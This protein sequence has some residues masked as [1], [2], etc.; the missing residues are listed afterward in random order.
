MVAFFFFNYL[1]Q[2][3]PG[4]EQKPLD[5]GRTVGVGGRSTA[6][7]RALK[8]ALQLT[9]IAQASLMF[10]PDR[11][12]R[13]CSVVVALVWVR[14][15][16]SVRLHTSPDVTQISRLDTPFLFEDS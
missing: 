15:M 9:A 12:V 16:R 1:V 13:R 11:K 8:E 10:F 5:E 3:P 14:S 7:E 6:E 2:E 4:F